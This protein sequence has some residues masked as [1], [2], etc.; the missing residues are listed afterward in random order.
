[1]KC[2]AISTFGAL[3]TL[4]VLAGSVRAAALPPALP[5][6][7]GILSLTNVPLDLIPKYFQMM[8]K[9][10]AKDDTV[11]ILRRTINLIDPTLC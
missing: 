1:M 10:N 4:F 9:C 8:D 11:R 7:N 5:L 6:T 3:T 2:F